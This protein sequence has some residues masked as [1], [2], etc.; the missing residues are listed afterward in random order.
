M[1][2]TVR[3]I[4]QLYYGSEIGMR[5]KKSMGDADIRRD[6]PGGWKEDVQNAFNPS[7]QTAN[8]KAFFDFTKKILTW[9][10]S[11]EVIHSGKTKHY[12]PKDKTYVYFRYNDTEKVMVVLNN[13][14][15]DQKL[16]L[17][18]FAENLEGVST[19]TDVISGLNFVLSPNGTLP[20]TAKTSLI[21]ELK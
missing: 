12:M 16:D 1:I 13:S 6:F 11:K 4:P 18:R 8:Q 5:G 17:S 2:A 10:K 20:L 14:E 21:L 15:K 3:G 9:R 7:A 19:G